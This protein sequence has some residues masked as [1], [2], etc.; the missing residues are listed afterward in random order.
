MTACGLFFALLARRR[1]MPADAAPGGSCRRIVV[2]AVL[3]AVVPAAASAA[4]LGRLADS[5]LAV[6]PADAAFLSASLRLREQYD[7]LVQSNAWAALRDLPGVKRALDSFEEQ[8][9]MPG[10]P[11]SMVDTFV[12]LPENAQAVELLKDMVSRDTFVYG[13]PSCIAF[14][15]LVQKLQQAQQMAGLLSGPE[16]A[17]L[18]GFFELEEETVEDEPDGDEAGMARR[19][20]VRPVAMQAVDALT[21]E[22]LQ[23]RAVIEVLADNLDLLVVPDVVWGFAISRREPATAQLERLEA[24]ARLF[25][26]GNPDLADA[27]ARA[28][29]AGAEFVTLTLDGDRLPWDEIE[30]E[31]DAAD[32]PGVDD[33]I[34]RLRGL[35]L[36][37]ALGVV[38]D[39]VILS[40]GDSVDHLKKLVGPAEARL[41]GQP[42]CAPLLEHRDAPLTAVS[43]LSA[44]LAAAVAPAAPDGE[45]IAAFVSGLAEGGSLSD[46]ATADIEKWLSEGAAGYARRLPEPGPW[47]G[48]S[49][50]TD[51]GYEGYAWDWSKSRTLDGSKRL[52]LLEHS[53]GA[54]V[55]V[56]VSRLAADATLLDD[57]AAF[58]TGGWQ[59]LDRRV[60]AGA[61]RGRAADVAARLAPLGEKFSTTLRTKLVP[62]LADGQVGFVI[63]SKTKVK[64]LHRELPG[65]AD[66]LPV[67]EPAV[68]LP[69]RDAKLF[70]EGLSD[71]FALSDELVDA[72]EAI[73]PDAVP[74]GYRVP[75]PEKAKVEA[76]S[77][78]SFALPRSGLDDAVRPAIGVGERV[79]VFSLVPKQAGRLLA[80]NRL[81]TGAQLT[82][83]E[84]P[85]AAGAALDVPGLI[86]ALE[87]WI[88][89]LAR[90]GS[91]QQREG[92]VNPT[93]ELSAADENEQ[94]KDVLEHVDVVLDVAR[95]LRAAVAET[96]VRDDAT[97]THWRNVIRD[98]P[99]KP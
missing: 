82:T 48:Y 35:D 22:D 92:E 32:V 46:E 45:T 65:S 78:W 90:Y 84:E 93:A 88:A 86:D 30:R 2:A 25:T 57:L 76:G 89:Y 6:V 71:V 43:Y 70:R 34:E 44:P 9:S 80:G 79:A 56:L 17:G 14:V 94:A 13:E 47:L 15:K 11:V 23:K 28:Q 21:P 75:D 31:L 4:D 41:V 98:L 7:R 16:R 12:E 63:D 8:R 68:V 19:P 10:S 39:R 81:E 1:Q 96:A 40:V 36:V 73:D 50:M 27:V 42:A 64:R 20:R 91:V 52:D 54:P 85:L 60:L 61:D 38:G 67:P 29:V 58:V 26:Q 37:V 3:A 62:A 77:I 51:L 24:L 69:L 87:P 99:A 97:V 74:D 18:D 55:A 49:F 95:C 83:F 33:V 72:L 5:G 66:P 59:I 53:G